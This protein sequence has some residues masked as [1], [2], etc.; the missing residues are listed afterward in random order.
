M[1]DTLTL[2]KEE[3]AVIDALE[4]LNVI[5]LNN[6]VKFMEKQYGI[7]AAAPVAAAAA[8]AAAAPDA[9]EKSSYDVELTDAG[10][11]KI[12]VIKVL[13]ELTQLGLGEAKE[14]TEKTPA[15]IKKGAAKADADAMKKKIE[16]AGGKV[17]LK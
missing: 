2:A 5:Q 11:Q 17:T 16:A 7:S 8:P 10:A 9:E 1:S 14:M 3:Q 13:R 12:A 15:M 6:V 4:K